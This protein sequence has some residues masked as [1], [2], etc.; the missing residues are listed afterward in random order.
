MVTVVP[1]HRSTLRRRRRHSA[2]TPRGVRRGGS[3]DPALQ[4]LPGGC[5]R[6]EGLASRAGDFRER[7]A[8][9][10]SHW[11]STASVEQRWASGPDRADTAMLG[12]VARLRA[13]GVRVAL[14]TN[15][16]RISRFMS[17]VLGYSSTFDI[18]YTRAISAMQNRFEYFFPCAGRSVSS[19]GG[20]VSGRS[21]G[22]EAARARLNRSLPSFPGAS[23]RDRYWAYDHA[24]DR[25]R[26][27]AS[28]FRIR[29]SAAGAGARL[30]VTPQ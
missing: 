21:A 23:G 15:N 20:A 28:R 22:S 17:S 1:T 25:P 5:V 3:Q 16:K 4:R 9:V 24:S 19:M 12:I 26:Q 6:G 7:L 2:A 14:A 29:A 8:Q 11:D 27:A 18:F 30:Q 13:D 10:L